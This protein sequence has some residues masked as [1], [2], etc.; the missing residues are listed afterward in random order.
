MGQMLE[1]HDW[2]NYQEKA[3][4]G[5]MPFCYYSRSFVLEMVSSQRS[6]TTRKEEIEWTTTRGEEVEIDSKGEVH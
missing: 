3:Q 2:K 1:E 4:E 6:K 5:C